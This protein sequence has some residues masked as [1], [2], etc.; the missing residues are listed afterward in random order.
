SKFADLVSRRMRPL[1]YQNQIAGKKKPLIRYAGSAAETSIGSKP[2]GSELE[3]ELSS[4]IVRVKC[5]WHS[6]EA[7][8]SPR[9]QWKLQPI[10]F[11]I[12]FS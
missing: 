7:P 2:M 11:N 5:A 1:A 3:A 8:R 10:V 9:S 4:A 6:G 12:K